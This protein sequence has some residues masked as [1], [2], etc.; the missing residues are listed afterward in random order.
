MSF[1]KFLIFLNFNI[2]FKFRY[3]QVKNEGTIDYGSAETLAFGSLLLE[4]Y[5]VRIT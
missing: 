2:F 3:D 4:G 5:G 1:L